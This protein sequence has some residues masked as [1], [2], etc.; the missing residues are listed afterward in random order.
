MAFKFMFDIT[1]VD[2]MSWMVW[3]ALEPFGMCM[4]RTAY[5]VDFGGKYKQSIG[6]FGIQSEIF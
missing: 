4:D 6:N 2:M 3:M 5:I 1:K